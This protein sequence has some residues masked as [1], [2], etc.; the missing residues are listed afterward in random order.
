MMEVIDQDV[1][2][3]ELFSR[4]Q[5]QNAILQ[6]R[7]SQLAVKDAAGNAGGCPGH[8]LPDAGGYLVF[9]VC[10]PGQRSCKRSNTEATR[11][12]RTCKR[13]GATGLLY[14]YGSKYN[15]Q[16]FV[17]VCFLFLLYI[18]HIARLFF[19]VSGWFGCKRKGKQF[20]AM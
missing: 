12:H 15:D 3:Q 10:L 9:S 5:G 2:G 20:N 16:L 13:N 8:G 11:H 1:Y 14:C 18:E 4:Q 17:R 19:P 6:I 7:T